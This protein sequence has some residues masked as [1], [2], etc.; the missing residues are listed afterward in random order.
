LGDFWTKSNPNRKG[1]PMLIDPFGSAK[2][3]P[4]GRRVEGFTSAVNEIE[5]AHSPSKILENTQ[6]FLD[7]MV[8]KNY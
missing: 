5:Q 6:V 1:T 3:R 8:I 7:E 4:S 2:L